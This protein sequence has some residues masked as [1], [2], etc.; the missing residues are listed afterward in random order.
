MTLDGAKLAVLVE[1]NYQELELWYPVLRLREEGAEVFIVGPEKGRTFTSKHDYPATADQAA[2]DVAINALDAVI[3]P[4][5]YAPDLMRRHP[6]MVRLVRDAH[7]RGVLVAAI[8]HAAWMLVS[9]DVLRGRK[10][11]CVVNVKDDLVNAGAAY[12]DAEVVRDGNLVTS[13]EP[14][15]LPAF[16]RTII[17]ALV[18]ARVG[19]AQKVTV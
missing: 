11:T 10:A 9:A 15:D 4:G 6:S 18:E 3:V 14:K 7:E 2:D 8:C 5:G 17:A 1:D 12:V 16:C 13:R 19:E